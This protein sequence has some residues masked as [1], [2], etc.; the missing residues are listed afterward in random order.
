M[1]KVLMPRKT[2]S[3]VSDFKVNRKFAHSLSKLGLNIETGGEEIG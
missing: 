3:G 2:A 1:L